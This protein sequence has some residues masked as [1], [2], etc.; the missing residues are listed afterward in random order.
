M[1]NEEFG[2]DCNACENRYT[3]LVK[4]SVLSLRDTMYKVQTHSSISIRS[5]CELIAATC[6]KSE[7]REK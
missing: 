2:N 4:A 1:L 6:E 5:I 3:C 7:P